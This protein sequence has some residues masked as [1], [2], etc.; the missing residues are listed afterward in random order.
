MFSIKM[1]LNK[2][3]F[4]KNVFNLNKYVFNKN[5]DVFNKNKVSKKIFINIPTNTVAVII[6]CIMR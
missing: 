6:W 5:K 2:N 3:V 1:F 4:N